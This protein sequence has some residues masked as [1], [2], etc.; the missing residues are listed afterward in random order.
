VSAFAYKG[1]DDAGF[2]AWLAASDVDPDT[3]KEYLR[4]VVWVAGSVSQDRPEAEQQLW[5]LTAAIIRGSIEKDLIGEVLQKRDSEYWR[6][7]RARNVKVFHRRYPDLV[8]LSM[9]DMQ[10]STAAVQA[11][12]SKTSPS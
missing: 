11:E 1:D 6:S 8:V 9:T 2:A 3:K 7:Y 10:Q 5:Q 4:Y 12:V